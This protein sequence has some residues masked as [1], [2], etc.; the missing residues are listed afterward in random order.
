MSWIKYS[1]DRGGHFAGAA[2]SAKTGLK[3]LQADRRRLKILMI[4]TIVAG[5]A[6]QNAGNLNNV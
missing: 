2:V 5:M 1:P 3:Q 4:S 6:K